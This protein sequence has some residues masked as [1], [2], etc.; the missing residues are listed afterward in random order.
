ME[1]KAGASPLGSLWAEAE[2]SCLL[3]P[4]CAGWLRV[5]GKLLGRGQEFI[6][7][8][9]PVRVPGWERTDHVGGWLRALTQWLPQMPFDSMQRKLTDAPRD[10]VHLCI[11]LWTWL[12]AGSC[13]L[14]LGDLSS[15]LSKAEPSHKR[16]RPELRLEMRGTLCF[17]SDSQ[18]SQTSELEGRGEVISDVCAPEHKELLGGS[19]RIPERPCG[20]DPRPPLAF[21][22][23]LCAGPLLRQSAFVAARGSC[24]PWSVEA[25]SRPE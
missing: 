21:L 17:L 11:L 9:C 16:Q 3:S 22:L 13:P 25:D 12:F 4:P 5:A 10:A 18:K 1:R 20:A 23:F 14:C 24:P 15:L 2:H 6:R 7:S 8:S 19:A